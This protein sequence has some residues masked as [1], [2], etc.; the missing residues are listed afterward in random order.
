MI[1]SF[2][3]K[4]TA[5][6]F[7]GGVPRGMAREVAATAHRKLVALNAAEGLE[8]LYLPPGNRLETL[9]G[10]RVGAYSIRVN[11]RWRIVFFCRGD[12][13]ARQN[14]RLSVV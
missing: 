11:N 1:R 5:M 12:Q 13:Y 9:R 4:A 2:R 7:S 14:G 10:D 8:D 3:D 6:V